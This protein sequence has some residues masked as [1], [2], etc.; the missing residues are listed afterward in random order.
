MKKFLALGLALVMGVASIAVAAEF[1]SGL[2]SGQKIPAFNV[3]K[4][5]GASDDG[6]S[7]GAELCYRCKYGA[8]PQ[9][10]VFARKADDKLAALVKGLDE[11]VA[12][13]GDKQLKAFVNI[14]ADSKDA[15]DAAAKSFAAST[16]A[17]TIPVVV[18]VEYANGPDNYGINPAA[19]L[20]VIVANAS[21]VVAN[22]AFEK[23]AFCEKCIENVLAE[24]AKLVK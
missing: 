22:H 23:D 4:I 7:V 11:L 3:V 9:V 17:P 16:K 24:V 6:V 10:M 15:A 21:T 18:P 2:Q 19:E 13:N 14:M 20:T 1:K 12:K 8:R 5:A